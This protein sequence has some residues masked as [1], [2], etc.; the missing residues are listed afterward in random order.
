MGRGKC[1]A[2]PMASLASLMHPTLALPLPLHPCTQTEHLQQQH[3][4]KSGQFL[5]LMREHV[6]MVLN[7]H[8]VYR[9]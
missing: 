7:D 2:W 9:S 5:G 6:E 1:P 8:E 4:R 3:W